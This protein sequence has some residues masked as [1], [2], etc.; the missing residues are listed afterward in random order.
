MNTSDWIINDFYVHNFFF[1][2]IELLQFVRDKL[3]FSGLSSEVQPLLA[4]RAGA[5]SQQA[6]RFRSEAA[7]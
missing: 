4:E 6:A 7:V 3:G 2:Q 1:F 5:E